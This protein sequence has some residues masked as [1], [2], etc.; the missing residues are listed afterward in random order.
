MAALWRGLPTYHHRMST[1]V[2]ERLGAGLLGWLADAWG[3]VHQGA[4]LVVL[5]LTPGSWGA[6]ERAALKREIV[7]GTLPALAVFAVLSALLSLIIIRIVVV[8]ALSYG[9]SRYALEMVVRVLVLELIPL[10]AA[11][12]AALRT[13]LPDAVDVAALRAR[14]ALDALHAEGVDPLQR[15]VVPRVVSGLFCALTLAVASGVLTLVL[16]YVSVYGFTPWGFAAYTRTVGQVLSPAVATI[17]VMKTL[18]FGA[19]VAL[20]PMASVLQEGRRARRG[21]AELRGLVRMFLAVLVVE[22]ASLAGNYG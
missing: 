4:L 1:A 6:A 14:G 5:A 3:V 12:Y 13:T 20:I 10:A 17:F 7:T 2:H 18:L 16:A 9:L 8:T 19:A 21:S 22:A 15:E 11:L